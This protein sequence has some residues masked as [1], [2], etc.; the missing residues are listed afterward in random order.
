MARRR[1]IVRDAVGGVAHRIDA[2]AVR[3]LYA[4]VSVPTERERQ[5][6]RR[7]R[8][9]FVDP[10]ADLPDRIAVGQTADHVV[11]QAVFGA[12][13]L[14]GLAGL[15]GMATVPPE[16]AA[17]MV[18]VVRLA[19]R[20]AV[21]YGFDPGDDRGQMALQ[22]A[23][24]AGLQV[25][26]PDGGPLGLKVSDLPQVLAPRVPR[27][28]TVAMTQA[29]VRQTAWMVVGSLGR[30]IPGISAGVGAAGGRR[31]MREIGHRMKDALERLS[32]LPV[33][34][35]GVV[36]AVEIVGSTP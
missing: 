17:T 19:Q 1:D 12:T 23:L 33:A 13:T 35:A 27:E 15:G 11:D 6:L 20:L 24:S 4:A 7:T 25:E 36:D 30:F 3:A 2:G 31:R 8:R 32:G 26:L 14:G 9:V 5:R 22:Q 28:V 18:A 16:V 21:V 34:D 10:E 29:L